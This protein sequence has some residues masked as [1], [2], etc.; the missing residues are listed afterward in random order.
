VQWSAWV[1]IATSSQQKEFEN[2]V[3]KFE[4]NLFAAV[5]GNHGGDREHLGG[6]GFAEKYP[7]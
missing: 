4:N 1:C 6:M 2:T 3:D 5:A 7:A